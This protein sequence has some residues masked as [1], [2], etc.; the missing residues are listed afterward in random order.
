[1]RSAVMQEFIFLISVQMLKVL[2]TIALSRIQ[3]CRSIELAPKCNRS[4]FHSDLDRLRVLPDDCTL[5]S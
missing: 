5:Q 3:T 4:N 1:M 2:A